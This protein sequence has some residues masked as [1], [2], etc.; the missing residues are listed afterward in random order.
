[1]SEAE[2]VALPARAGAVRID[3]ALRYAAYA[4]IE[5][6]QAV[7]ERSRALAVEAEETEC[8]Q[9]TSASSP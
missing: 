8:A 3:E 7:R 4:G 1:M 9:G 2:A 5:E 6:T